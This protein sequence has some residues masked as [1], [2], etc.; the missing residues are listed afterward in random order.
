MP[1]EPFS[2]EPSADFQLSQEPITPPAAAAAESPAPAPAY[3]HL[4][5][6]PTGYGASHVYLVA[7][8]PRRLF[9]Y[10]DLDA[11]V[12]ASMDAPLALRVCRA[13]S[14]QVES[15]VDLGRAVTLLG[16]VAAG[17]GPGR[18]LPVSHPGV[19]YRVEL[20]TG[21]DPA[22]RP[23]R[24]LAV[25]GVVT[26][27]PEGLA[28]VEDGDAHF[29][30]LPFHLS[31]QRLADLLRATVPA[32]GQPLTEAL[33]KLQFDVHATVGDAALGEALSRLDD[34]QRRN[35]E[36]VL[37]WE[38]EFP[39]ADVGSSPGHGGTSE[40]FLAGGRGAA[41]SSLG[42]GALA[43]PGT[44]SGGGSGGLTAA[45]PSSATM[46]AARAA[47]GS[48]SGRPSSAMF[49]AGLSRAALFAAGG[50]SSGGMLGPGPS[51]EA[52]RRAVTAAGAMTG[53][54]GGSDQFAR[55]RAD[56]FLRAVTSSLDVLGPLFSGNLAAGASSSG[57]SPG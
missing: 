54:S 20:G 51:S 24:A 40:N 21:G 3:E 57:G 52:W 15:Q 11:A 44:S 14:G 23:W 1:E 43:S 32:A 37:G 13:D 35:L 56:R 42:A 49:A 5:E 34:E 4:G 2:A 33:A 39:A 50:G 27:P 22:G 53:S 30:T 41:P 31:F 48:E 46:F 8:D 9:A 6:L 29:A 45:G 38:S 10:W 12:V 36:T 19:D 25:S 16:G 18:Y 26:V 55:D 47:A 17:G 28:A 7:Y